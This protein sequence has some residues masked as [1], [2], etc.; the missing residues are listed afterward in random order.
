MEWSIYILCICMTCWCLYI[1]RLFIM[2]TSMYNHIYIF[3][4][5]QMICRK[6]I[7]SEHCKTHWYSLYVWSMLWNTLT[8]V[9]IW[10]STYTVHVC[11]YICIRM[12]LYIYIYTNVNIRAHVHV[13]STCMHIC[14]HTHIYVYIYIFT[15][16]HKVHVYLP[17]HI[18][19]YI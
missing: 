8:T 14:T 2:T 12:Y 6:C 5:M 11:I 16:M 10:G 17:I 19:I 4:Y 15:H 18:H 7:A 3:I 13:H 1:Q 9:D